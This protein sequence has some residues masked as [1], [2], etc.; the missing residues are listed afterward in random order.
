MLKKFRHYIPGRAFHKAGPDVET[1]L[2]PV[3]VLYGEQQ[4][5]LNLWSIDKSAIYA[6][7][8]SFRV[9]KVIANILKRVRNLTGSQCYRFR[10]G[11]E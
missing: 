9:R 1:A 3:F 4:M 10:I 11:I 6:G 7:W 2:D 5:Y 8:L